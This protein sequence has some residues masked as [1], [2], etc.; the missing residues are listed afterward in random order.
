[1]HLI[2]FG[3]N[4]HT[5]HGFEK[6]SVQNIRRIPQCRFTC[7]GI[8]SRLGKRTFME[9]VGRYSDIDWWLTIV[10]RTE[11]R[12][13]RRKVNYQY[14]I[15]VTTVSVNWNSSTTRVKLQ[16]QLSGTKSGTEKG[17]T[18]CGLEAFLKRWKQSFFMLKAPQGKGYPSLRGL[19][20]RLSQPNY[21]VR[22]DTFSFNRLP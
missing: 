16:Y 13:C 18:S 20:Y 22:R 3:A 6:F 4:N 2:I 14:H 17:C 11:W 21:Y 12:A 9:T 7:H 19:C 15:S 1:M 5:L 8:S 10:R